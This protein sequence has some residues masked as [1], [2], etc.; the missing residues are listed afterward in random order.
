MIYPSSISL[1]YFYLCLLFVFPPSARLPAFSHS[2]N[3]V[4]FSRTFS[5]LSGARGRD[6]TMIRSLVS[7]RSAKGTSLCSFLYVGSQRRVPL[8]SMSQR[9]SRHPHSRAS[10]LPHIIHVA[11]YVTPSM[12]FDVNEFYYRFQIFPLT[13]YSIWI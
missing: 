13:F 3:F 12:I 11:F 6:A 2:V 7:G 5:R 1:S 9:A 4:F 8:S 10:P